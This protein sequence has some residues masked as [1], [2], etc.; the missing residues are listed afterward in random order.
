VGRYINRGAAQHAHP[1]RRVSK[2]AQ[3]LPIELVTANALGRQERLSVDAMVQTQQRRHRNN[4]ESIRSRG[5]PLSSG[6]RPSNRLH[7]L[8]DSM[9]GISLIGRTKPEKP[10]P[11]LSAACCY[12]LVCTPLCGL[13]TSSGRDRSPTDLQRRSISWA[14]CNL[15][16]Q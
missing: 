10:W 3:S 11:K 5:Q 13:S 2:S 16:E 12:W 9:S 7:V 14:R 15:A 4:S 1:Q 6:S 8:W